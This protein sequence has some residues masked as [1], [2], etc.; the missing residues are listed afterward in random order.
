ML[1][2][3]L[4]RNVLS[5]GEHYMLVFFALKKKVVHTACFQ[6]TRIGWL[7]KDEKMCSCVNK[8]S[9]GSVWTI[10]FTSKKQPVSL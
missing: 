10:A 7:E 9:E 1:L 6:C 4:K 2:P 5:A 8:N 3:L